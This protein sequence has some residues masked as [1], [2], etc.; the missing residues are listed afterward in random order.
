MTTERSTL[1]ATIR[2]WPI[3]PQRI[4]LVA[5]ML[6]ALAHGTAYAVIVPIWQAPD[7]TTLYEYAQLIV[8][9]GHV[10]RSEDRSPALEDRLIASMERQRF[11][12]YTLGAAPTAPLQ[13]LADVQ[14]IFD[15]PRQV[16]GDPPAYFMLAAL[17]LSLVQ[18]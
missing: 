6:L 1:P 15:M 11:W 3:L 7:E 10:P 13:T 16:G 14:A 12:R 5:L 8:E 17:P 4:G 18:H 9:L 2:R